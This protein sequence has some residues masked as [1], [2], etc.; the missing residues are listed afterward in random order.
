MKITSLKIYKGSTYEAEI[1][2]SRKIY[3]HADIISDFGIYQGMEV[4]SAEMKKIIYASNFRRA[5]QYA[6]YCLD[7]R[8]YSAKELL[9]KLV[10]RYKSEKLCGAVIKKLEN[11]GIVNDERYAERLAEKYVE[12]KK[13]GY[14]RAKH[15][16]IMKGIDEYMAEDVLVPYENIFTANLACLVEIKYARLLADRDDRKSIEKV[17]N[18][19]VRYGYS[20]DD[21]NRTVREYLDNREE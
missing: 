14:R 17:R 3:L 4:D 1:D 20:F 8:D 18:S 13:Y 21:I 19:L 12:G 16:I 11:L 5:Y 9:R 10:S 2:F 7:Y 6:L 15:E